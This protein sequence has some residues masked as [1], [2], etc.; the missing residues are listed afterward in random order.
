MTPSI[1]GRLTLTYTAVLCLVL[2]TFGAG[3]IWV[4]QRFARSQLDTDLTTLSDATASVLQEEL[5][6]S[7]DLRRAAVETRRSIDVPGRAIAVLDGG[8][9]PVAAHWRGLHATALPPLPKAAQFFTIDD[10]ANGWRVHVTK[11]YAEGTPYYILSAGGTGQLTRERR[12]LARTLLVATPIAVLFSA[13]FCWWAASRAL[14]PVTQMAQEAEAITAQSP[15][16]RLSARTGGDELEQLSQSFNR[17]LQ[18]LS[19]A[20]YSQRRFMA[21]ASHELRTPISIARTAA[22]LTLSRNARQE[23]EYRDAL[24]VVGDQT[25]RLGRIVEDMLVLARADTGGYPQLAQP[26]CVADLLADTVHAMGIL[27]ADRGVALQLAVDADASGTGDDAL[28]RQLA[29][30]LIDN[31]IEYTPRGG[32][33]AVALRTDGDA[34]VISVSDTGGG[35]AESDRERIFER[36]VRLDHGR[37]SGTG[38]GLGLPIARWIAE[39]HGGTLTLESN[40]D[41]GC[42][43][44]ARLRVL[45]RVPVQRTDRNVA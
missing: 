23:A 44:V 35:I 11:S 29:T 2:F 18:R 30:N 15:D 4:Q 37:E 3:V 33:V 34:A 26:I 16:V 27:A 12:L 5:S 21:D 6:K 45:G 24:A 9:R 25:V 20:L 38:A 8:G 1:R 13:A 10:G 39:L 36:F 7:H 17:L 31:A 32:A 14:R 19:T 22:D 41:G 43:F 42:T 40:A 28:L